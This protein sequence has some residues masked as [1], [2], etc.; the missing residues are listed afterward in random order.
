VAAK[1]VVTSQKAIQTFCTV[2]AMRHFVLLTVKL[3]VIIFVVV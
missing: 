1:I 2:T 3:T